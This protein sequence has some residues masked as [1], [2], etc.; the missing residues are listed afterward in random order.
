[1][2]I[3]L[4][5][6]INT[7]HSRR[8]STRLDSTRAVRTCLS[9]YIASREFPCDA[10]NFALAAM[11]HRCL[12]RSFTSYLCGSE[13]VYVCVCVTISVG[14]FKLIDFMSIALF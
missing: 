14:Q 4:M 11:M 6:K 9:V 12:N 2:Q 3:E 10:R 1:M 13:C 5:R 8:R 7:V